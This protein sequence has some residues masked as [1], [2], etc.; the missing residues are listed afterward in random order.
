[1]NVSRRFLA[2]VLQWDTFVD[3][4]VANSVGLSYP[5]ITAADLM[6]LDLVLPPLD[7]QRAIANYLDHETA[8]I[9]TLVSKQEEFIGLLR[10]R[11]RATITTA[12]TKGLRAHPVLTDSGVPSLG[13]IPAHWSVKKVKYLGRALIGLTYTPSQQVGPAEGWTLVLR[14]NNI[15][16]ECIDLTDNVYVH[17]P[18]P[19]DLRVRSG[20]ILICAR[21]GSARLIGKS[22]ILDSSLAGQTWG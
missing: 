6:A 20:D 15:Q 17:G 18:I 16:N 22:A 12:V 3:K 19:H 11:R 1:S 2:Y 14:E 9:D 7:E 5:A 13:A 21:N 10:E 8:R 4:V